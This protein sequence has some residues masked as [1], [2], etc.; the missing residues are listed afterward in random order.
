LSKNQHYYQNFTDFTKNR[1]IAFKGISKELS[2]K[3]FNLLFIFEKFFPLR[4]YGIF[5]LF[6]T[7]IFNRKK[8]F[9]K[10]NFFEKSL[11]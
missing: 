10:K 6:G 2:Q 11:G 9:S 7:E 8:K 1:S 5:S 3:K 4:P